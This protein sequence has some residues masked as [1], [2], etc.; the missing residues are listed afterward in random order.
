MT[1]E[2]KVAAAIDFGTHA[3]GFAWSVM[4]RLNDDPLTR[5]VT[6]GTG[7]AGAG[8]NCPKD[9]TAILVDREGQ[10]VA[11]GHAARARWATASDAGNPDQLGYA[12]AFKMAIRDGDAGPG[13]PTVG[14]SMS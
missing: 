2:P 5:K 12:Y 6:F 9:L 8:G 14:G 1:V 10:V 11:W 13:M 7:H 4:S 3:S